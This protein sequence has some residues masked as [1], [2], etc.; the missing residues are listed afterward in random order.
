MATKKKAAGTVIHLGLRVIPQSDLPA[1]FFVD[2]N[3]Y[4]RDMNEDGVPGV[5]IGKLPSTY[6]HCQPGQWYIR[7]ACSM[8]PD[9]ESEPPVDKANP[10]CSYCDLFG[11]ESESE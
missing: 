9:S 3:R 11:S 2:D 10:P 7:R 8:K 5:P 4:V 1:L 6:S